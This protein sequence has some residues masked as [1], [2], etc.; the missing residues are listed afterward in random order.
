MGRI[1]KGKARRTPARRR[2][3]DYIPEVDRARWV[4]YGTLANR[5]PRHEFKHRRGRRSAKWRGGIKPARAT[6]RAWEATSQRVYSNIP[7]EARA[8]IERYNRKHGGA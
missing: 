7:R 4:E 5:D 6:E 1:K 3:D 2:G 8:A